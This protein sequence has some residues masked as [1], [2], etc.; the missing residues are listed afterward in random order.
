MT[1]PEATP[2]RRTNGVEPPVNR[3]RIKE[4]RHAVPAQASE[5]VQET[6]TVETSQPKAQALTSAFKLLPIKTKGVCPYC[7][8][9]I[10]KGI[11]GHM[12]SCQHTA[13]SRIEST[14]IT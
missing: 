2:R 1:T 8:Q 14:S 13:K 4:T 12:Q 9:R 10:G 11:F 3:K 5:P 7:N 6:V